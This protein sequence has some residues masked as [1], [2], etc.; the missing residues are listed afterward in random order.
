MYTF[1]TAISLYSILLPSG[2][3]FLLWRRLRLPYRIIAAFVLLT[4]CMETI[5]YVLYQQ[6]VNNMFIFHIYTYVEAIM[7][8]SYFVS[9]YRGQ[10][11]RWLYIGLLAAFLLFSLFD[12][13]YFERLGH[14]NSI[15]RA[16]ECIWAVILFFIF[17]IELFNKSVVT[18]LSS[19][20]HYWMTSG[21]LLYFAGTLFMQIIADTYLSTDLIAY[22][23]WSI[24]SILNIFLNIIYT[25][26]LWMGSRELT[27]ER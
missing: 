11:L 5:S 23:V 21:F 9:I 22:N 17:Y 18:N 19:Y 10:R 4:L 26:V 12:S 27:S 6:G 15:Q 20:P 3:V 2:M 25:I 13:V 14:Y 24:H 1:L 16:V 8:V 7:V